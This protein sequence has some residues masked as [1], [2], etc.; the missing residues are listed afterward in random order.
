MGQERE[1]RQRRVQYE[2]AAT[3]AGIL[4]NP[5]KVTWPKLSQLQAAVEAKK[6]PGSL[7]VLARQPK[8]LLSGKK[9]CSPGFW[10]RRPS[11]SK[12]L[13]S[14]TTGEPVALKVPAG[15]CRIRFQAA[16]QAGQSLSPSVPQSLSPS[17]PQAL[18]P[19]GPQALRPS[20]PQ[21]Q[22][23]VG[24]ERRYRG[25]LSKRGP[26]GAEGSEA[27]GLRAACSRGAGRGEALGICS[28]GPS[29]ASSSFHVSVF[30]LRHGIAWRK[31][32]GRKGRSS[33]GLHLVSSGTL[34]W[35]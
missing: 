4:T 12:C 19:S 3:T 18:R 25:C 5:C 10:Q 26:V 7:H 29:A 14:V 20:G 33:R 2:Q 8:M 31:K 16:P 27:A 13:L 34:L 32:R 9:T 22:V 15:S 1:R 35:T 17:G 23:L 30:S 11:A 28:L 6:K 21:A 24:D